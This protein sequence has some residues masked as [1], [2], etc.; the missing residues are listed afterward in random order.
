MLAAIISLLQDAAPG[1]SPQPPQP[2]PSRPAMVK[3]DRGGGGPSWPSYD[4]VDIVG[5]LAT[6]QEQPGEH[7]VARAARRHRHVGEHLEAIKQGRER[8][9][10]AAF[11]AGAAVASAE[12]HD[13]YEAMQRLQIGEI[14]AIIDEVRGPS[15]IPMPPARARAR[16]E[17]RTRAG[18]MVAI[19]GIG[20]LIGTLFARSVSDGKFAASD[21]K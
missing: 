12:M 10:A 14:V 19:G 3:I 7:P 13:R 21:G 9:E 6:F 4:I 11:L 15:V 20:L 5:A 1:P 17:Y 18:A 16:G 8:R 2:Q